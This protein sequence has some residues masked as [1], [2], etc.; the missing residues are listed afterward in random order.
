MTTNQK[1][2]T[3]DSACS[4]ILEKDLSYV[5]VKTGIGR[6]ILRKF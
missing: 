2:G 6:K 5:H 3:N 4:L 1:A